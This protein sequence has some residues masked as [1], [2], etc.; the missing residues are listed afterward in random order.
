MKSRLCK[1]L[2]VLVLCLIFPL[3]AQ[4]SAAF[5][6]ALCHTQPTLIKGQETIFYSYLLDSENYVRLRDVAW[7]LRGTDAGFSVQWDDAQR[8]V[9]LTTGGA[10]D[11][12][13][14]ENTPHES[15]P[16]DPSLALPP[17]AQLLIDGQP[18]ELSSCL[19]DGSHYY[20]LRDLCAALSIPVWWDDARRIAVVGGD[21]AFESRTVMV[22]AGHGG[23]DIGAVSQWVGYEERL[24]YAVASELAGMLRAA[25]CRVVETR[26]EF[27]TVMLTARMAQVRALCPDLL[28]SV[29]HNA[30]DSHTATGATVLAQVGDE[31][32]GPSKTLA[33]L[34]GA[35]FAS[36][37]RPINDILF[38]KNSL[39]R[40][41]YGLL[42]AAADVSVPAV[43]TEY[44][45][46]DHPE[47]SYC[48]N[49]PE[50]L[51]AEANAIFLAVRDWFSSL[52]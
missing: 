48:V 41:Y 2:P 17:T 4:N 33:E 14:T 3:F 49:T 52:S 23:S 22:D 16:F 42:R 45:F 13:G 34:L 28:L 7:F 46:I 6:T 31:Y 24:N 47:D 9:S 10:Y 18:A 32:G 30:S 38:R 40:D 27:D 51:T 15:G 1:L 19:I 8:I 35:Y 11:P 50:K 37:G 26:G 39:G 25:G 20:R 44:A 29:H 43:I 5:D 21:P 12:L 36:Q